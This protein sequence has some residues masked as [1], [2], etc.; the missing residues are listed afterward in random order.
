VNVAN[1]I[2]AIALTGETMNFGEWCRAEI[3]RSGKTITWLAH[4]VGAHPSLIV[5]WRTRASIPKTEYFLKICKTLSIVQDRPLSQVL[6]E[7]AES[8]GIDLQLD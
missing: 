4:Q 3:T 8:M 7:G 6:K 5:K 2:H 1:A